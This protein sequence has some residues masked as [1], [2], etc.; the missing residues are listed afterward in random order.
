MLWEIYPIFV[1]WNIVVQLG[2]HFTS[3][4]LAS[5]HLTSPHL[6]SPNP[7][8]FLVDGSWGRWQDWSDCS[9]TCGQG[10]RLRK[11]GCREPENGGADCRGLGEQI[12][13]CDAPKACPGKNANNYKRIHLGNLLLMGSFD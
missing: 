2:P 7:S 12:V 3:P 9:E 1:N 10:T 11:R 8:F 4:R 5:P 6:T 13:T